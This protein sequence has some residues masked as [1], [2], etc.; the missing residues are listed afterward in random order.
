MVGPLRESN[1]PSLGTQNILQLSSFHP[2]HPV[3]LTRR[4]FETEAAYHNVADETLETLQDTLD[5]VL[6]PVVM[7]YELTL[8]NGVLTLVI[9]NHGTWV[10]NKQTPTQ[11]IWWSSPLSGPKRF[12][13]LDETWCSTKNGLTL[14]PLLVQE[15]RHV[16]PDVPEF[17]VPV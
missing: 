12:E 10:L 6:E 8:A 11:Q 16:L 9:P 17:Q 4:S 15:I 1:H 13:Y 7:E 3:L 2:S 5:D 14:G